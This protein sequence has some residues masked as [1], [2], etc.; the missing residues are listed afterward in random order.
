MTTATAATAAS[1]PP[2][3]SLRPVRTVRLL[4]VLAAVCAVVLGFTG[5]AYLVFQLS[6]V[7]V[8]F[9]VLLGL[10][11]LTADTGLISVG[12]GALMGIGAYVTGILVVHANASYL[13]A[14]PVAVL[15]C[16]LLGGL[17]GVPALRI[18]GLYLALVTLSVA[19]ALGPV[20]IRF[21]DLT[22]GP[23]GISPRPPNLVVNGLTGDQSRYLV[24]VACAL[25]SA[26]ATAWFRRSPWGRRCHAVKASGQMAA[27][28]GIDVATTKVLSFVL[29]SALAGLA[30]GLYLTVLG[31]VAPST[32]TVLLSITLLAAAVV[33]GLHSQS[34]ALLGALF[35]VFLPD[36]TAGMSGQAPQIV[37]ALALLI[38]VY[39]APRGVAG[40]V[41]AA[42]ARVRASARLHRRITH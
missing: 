8:I 22:G 31:A 1:A 2:R 28:C 41:T 5:D 20:L 40:L 33:G 13:W 27:A 6:Q 36:A 42:A 15:T 35:F 3:T 21:T 4:V 19:I 16:G 24:A 10:N 34:G 39:F 17:L 12:H 7:A 30:G 9:I 23:L 11:L 25:A 26:I 38:A 18:R 14:V 32:F 37:Y 29:S